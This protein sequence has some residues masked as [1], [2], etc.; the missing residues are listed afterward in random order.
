MNYEK[1][2][3][4]IL[5]HHRVRNLPSRAAAPTIRAQQKQTAGLKV[6]SEMMVSVVRRFWANGHAAGQTAELA[7]AESKAE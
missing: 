4:D 7:P 1:A 3:Q 6:R 2:R 5:S